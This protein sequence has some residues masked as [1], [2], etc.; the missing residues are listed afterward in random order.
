MMMKNDALLA[1][2][3]QCLFF[4]W[5]FFFYLYL[6]FISI[7]CSGYY[8]RLKFS[9]D[10]YP[11]IFIIKCF[12]IKDIMVQETRTSLL[13]FFIKKKKKDSIA[14][15]L[16]TVGFSRKIKKKYFRFYDKRNTFISL[17]FI[18]RTRKGVL[19]AY[20]LAA[21]KKK[22]KV[23]YGFFKSAFFHLNLTSNYGSFHP[24][25]ICLPQCHCTSHKGSMNCISLTQKI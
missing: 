24:K 23:H 6:F 25:K 21:D 4:A 16:M 22:D 7:V 14:H 17:Y 10:V 15:A 18:L 13:S 2:A 20:C 11:G 5:Y 1:I 9:L 8:I 19:N 3:W 12:N